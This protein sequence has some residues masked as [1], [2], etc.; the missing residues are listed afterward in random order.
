MNAGHLG[1]IRR[2]PPWIGHHPET[3]MFSLRAIPGCAETTKRRAQAD[4]SGHEET[5]V[6][7]NP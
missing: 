1:P 2:R 4:F 6:E 5:I 7:L 3:L